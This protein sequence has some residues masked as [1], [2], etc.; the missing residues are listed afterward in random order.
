[1]CGF[2]VMRLTRIV[3][4]GSSR[5]REEARLGALGKGG[6]KSWSRAAR[7][8]A[9]G[10]TSAT[11]VRAS[12][13]VSRLEPLN[14]EHARRTKRRLTR[15]VRSIR[16]GEVFGHRPVSQQRIRDCSRNIHE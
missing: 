16:G 15:R 1:M 2:V 7:S 14:D 3:H 12:V 8:T 10:R 11:V 9:R 5:T 4:D 13:T 6:C